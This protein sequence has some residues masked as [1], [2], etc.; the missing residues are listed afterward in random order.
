MVNLCNHLGGT[1]KETWWEL[2][3]NSLEFKHDDQN[4]EYVT[5]KH[6]IRLLQLLTQAPKL[7]LWTAGK[8]LVFHPSVHKAK[9]DSMS[10][11]RRHYEKRGF[12]E[13]VNKVLLNSWRPSNQKQWAVFCR[14]WQI[15]SLMDMLEFLHTQL[16]LSYSAL[17]TDRSALSCV[18]SIDNVPVGQHPLLSR[19]VKGTFERKPPFGMYAKC[20]SF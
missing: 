1:G 10:F 15:T 19:F 20:L 17:N 5:T 3:K 6:T 14:E 12:S 16:H 9:I 2:T 13:H 11:I 4:K 7:M 18:I 8:E